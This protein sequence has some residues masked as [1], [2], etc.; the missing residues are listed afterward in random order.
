MATSDNLSFRGNV[1]IARRFPY[2][3]P[4]IES[5]VKNGVQL[6]LET[7]GFDEKA[8]IK[9]QAAQRW[10]NAVNADGRFGA[11]KY[12]MVKSPGDVKAAIEAA[13]A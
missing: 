10:V 11:W 4:R 12:A 1:A 2:S 9:A 5:F 13:G 7:K 3:H 8:D 6:S